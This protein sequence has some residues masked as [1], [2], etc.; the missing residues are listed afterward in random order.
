MA[1]GFANT[2]M[3]ACAGPWARCPGDAESNCACPDLSLRGYFADVLRRVQYADAQQVHSCFHAKGDPC[4]VRCV[5]TE[6]VLIPYLSDKI[7]G[8]RGLEIGPGPSSRADP[9]AQLQGTPFC[10][11]HGAALQGVFGWALA[12]VGPVGCFILSESCKIISQG[13]SISKAS[14]MR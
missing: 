2:V 14:R 9:R 5:A 3:S 8:L 4:E 7:L 6:A 1:E 11:M 10:S 13:H 12:L